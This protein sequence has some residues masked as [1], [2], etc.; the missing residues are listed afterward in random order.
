VKKL[1]GVTREEEREAG[2][3]IGDSDRTSTPGMVRASLGCYSNESDIDLFIEMLEKIVRREYKGTY[4]QDSSTG[5]FHPDGY[6]MD[7]NK[8]FSF[9]EDAGHVKDRSYSEAS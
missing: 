9:F 3:G 2:C 5:A 8:Y 1:L 7:L 4:T 6:R